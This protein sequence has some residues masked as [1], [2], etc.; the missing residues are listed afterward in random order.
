MIYEIKVTQPAREDVTYPNPSE[1]GAMKGPHGEPGERD[2]AT[3]RAAGDKPK[4]PPDPPIAEVLIE[5]LRIMW[6]VSAAA[7]QPPAQEGDN[8]TTKQQPQGSETRKVRKTE[9]PE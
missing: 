6:M 8:H 5:H 7:V 9:K 2:W 3:K 4:D 1:H